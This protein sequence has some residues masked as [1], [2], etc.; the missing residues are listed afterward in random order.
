MAE[1]AP[2]F[3]KAADRHLACGN[4]E[5]AL[6]SLTEGLDAVTGDGRALALGLSRLSRLLLAAGRLPEAFAAAADAL[7]ASPGDGEVAREAET[8]REQAT[9][10]ATGGSSP[11]VNL[12]RALREFL[13]FTTVAD[14]MTVRS[15]SDPAAALLAEGFRLRPDES[16]ELAAMAAQVADAEDARRRADFAWAVTGRALAHASGHVGGLPGRLATLV[17]RFGLRDGEARLFVLAALAVVHPDAGR[18]VR[19]CGRDPLA[20]VASLADLLRMTQP[21]EPADAFAA[22]LGPTAVLRRY[23]LLVLSDPRDGQPS[24][25]GGPAVPPPEVV[26]YLLSGDALSGVE[27]FGRVLGTTMPT[28]EVCM[29][30]AVRDRVADAWES[31]VA[32]EDRLLLAL[33]GSPGCGRRTLAASLAGGYSLCLLVLPWDR[34]E[35]AVAAAGPARVASAIARASR[36][37]GLVPYVDVTS[38]PEDSG[39]SREGPSPSRG[40]VEAPWTLAARIAPLLDTPIFLG[41]PLAAESDPA[42]LPGAILFDVPPPD[43]AA[44]GALVDSLLG[45]LPDVPAAARKALAEAVILPAEAAS[46]CDRLRRSASFGACD[47]VAQA[48]AAARRRASGEFGSYATRIVPGFCP[49]DLVAPPDLRDRLDEIVAFHRHRRLVFDQWGFG[50]KLPYGRAL[51]AL[52]SGPPGTGKTMA[53]TIVAAQLE[54]DLFRVDLSQVVSKYVGETEKALS[55]VFE[56][57]SRYRSMVLFDEAEALFGKRG[58]VR[59]G[60]DRYAN[61]EVNF[62]LQMME[63]FDGVTILT[64]N[65]PQNVDEAFKRRLRFRI[66]FPFPDEELRLSLWQTMIPPE[67]PQAATLDLSSLARDFEMSGAHIKNA[68]IRAA[69]NAARQGVPLSGDHLFD[70][71]RMEYEELGRVVRTSRPPTTRQAGP[72]GS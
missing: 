14:V 24:V 29:D 52:F 37:G 67:A 72:A 47:L 18:L 58:E 12:R 56:A 25:L 55:R 19:I 3:V 49:E 7:A 23:G 45:S 64:T 4:L 35:V 38:S 27:A 60:T 31:A 68:A 28:G 48:H 57:A 33:S 30:P 63:D 8:V 16:E 40:S 61:L 62:L 53:A 15:T 9:A 11:D 69:F 39:A 51:S 13:A 32:S 36:L 17:S 20:P 59:S 41:L 50:R 42:R 34:V 21:G 71:A 46:L 70:A 66:T 44:I 10:L 54:L 43:R 2:E 65:F 22:V 26:E 1:G 6:R 5:D